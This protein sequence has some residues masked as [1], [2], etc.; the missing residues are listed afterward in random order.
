MK[1]NY[2]PIETDYSDYQPL[3]QADSDNRHISVPNY[4]NPTNFR[5][6]V[7]R[8]PKFTYFIQSITVPSLS[9]SSI[10]VG[11]KGFPRTSV[12]SAIDI[13]DQIILTF[14]VD[15]DMKNWQ[16]IYDWMTAIV[17]S[18]EN[19]GGVKVVDPYSEIIVLIYNAQKKLNKKITYSSC[20]PVNLGSFD[21]NSTAT[22]ID[23]II[24]TANFAYKK[25]DIV[26]Y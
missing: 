15:E 21:M 7:P 14:I 4:L 5:V 19:D 11:F 18:K 23:P 24:L 22:S 16:D 6:V 26:S 2:E 20:H 10:D 3:A 25:I 1:P 9:M 12:P 17:P 13:T 8:L